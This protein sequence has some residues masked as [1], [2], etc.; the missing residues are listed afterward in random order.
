MVDWKDVKESN[1]EGNILD[2]DML[3][4]RKS[5]GDQPFQMISNELK[6]EANHNNFREYLFQCVS[7]SMWAHK[8]QLVFACA[9]NDLKLETEL[10]RLGTSYD[11]TIISYGISNNEL[12]K[13]PMLKKYF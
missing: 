6:I 9:I 10:S 2:S 4:I 7:N 13:L 8:A 5:L 1:D 3:E 12:D 11:V